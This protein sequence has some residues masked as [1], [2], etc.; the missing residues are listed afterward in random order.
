MK[1]TAK[2]Y[3]RGGWLEFWVV[4][5]ICFPMLVFAIPFAIWECRRSHQAKMIW[6]RRATR[7]C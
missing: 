3:K 6:N 5:V 1:H 4:H 7:Y 2:W